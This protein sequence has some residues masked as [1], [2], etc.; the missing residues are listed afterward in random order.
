ME[1]KNNNDKLALIN[2]AESVVKHLRCSKTNDEIYDLLK[3]EYNFTDEF[4]D[5][6]M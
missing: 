3:N 6:I 1:L 4:I 5:Q 2:L